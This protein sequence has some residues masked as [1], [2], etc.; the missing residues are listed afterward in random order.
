MRPSLLTWLCAS[1]LAGFASVWW[2]FLSLSLSL[3]QARLLSARDSATS[4]LATARLSARS[5]HHCIRR[6]S[7]GLLEVGLRYVGPLL[8][9]IVWAICAYLCTLW[10]HCSFLRDPASLPET[11]RHHIDEKFPGC[12]HFIWDI[13]SCRTRDAN[14]GLCSH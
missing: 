14:V 3:S 12:P 13:F 11:L 2:S 4:Y 5:L 10:S 8:R 9:V 1:L 7:C 6:L